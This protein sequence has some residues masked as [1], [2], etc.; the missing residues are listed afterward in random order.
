VLPTLLL[1]A[2]AVL[3]L[4]IFLP[5]RTPTLLLLLLL[6]YPPFVENK[7]ARENHA[8]NWYECV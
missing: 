8:W 6:L 5:M 1:L 3:E 4:L 2:V 7:H